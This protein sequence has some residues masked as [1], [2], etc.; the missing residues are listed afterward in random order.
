MFQITGVFLAS[1]FSFS[2]PRKLHI[3][4]VFEDPSLVLFLDLLGTQLQLK[5]CLSPEVHVQA[6][7]GVQN[8]GRT[9]EGET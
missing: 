2:S 3:L 4:E 8:S 9:P 5:D 7:C 6:L 1:G